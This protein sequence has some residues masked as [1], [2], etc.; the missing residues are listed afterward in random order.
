MRF[1]AGLFVKDG[2]QLLKSAAFHVTEPLV[3][4]ETDP[5]EDLGKARA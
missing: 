2:D 5:N 3:G 4:V 1:T